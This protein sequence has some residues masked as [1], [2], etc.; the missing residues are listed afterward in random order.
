MD[1]ALAI[2][3]DPQRALRP[4]QSGSRCRRRGRNRAEHLAGGGVDLLDAILGDL[5]QVPAVER[6]PRMRGDIDERAIL[7]LAG[8]TAFSL[9]PDANQTCVPS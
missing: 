6:R 9:S 7:P 2:L 4:G 1:L 8:S 5:E 3:T